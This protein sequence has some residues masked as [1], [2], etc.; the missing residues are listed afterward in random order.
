MLPHVISMHLIALQGELGIERREWI[1]EKLGEIA[2]FGP[3]SL[4]V[5]DLTDVS[6]AD[7]TLLHAL[8]QVKK[9]I[10]ALP[11]SGVYV[12]APKYIERLFQI[13]ELD[14]TF[15]LFENVLSA[16]WYGLASHITGADS[17]PNLVG[18]QT[19]DELRR[20]AEIETA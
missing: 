12:V 1:E 10:D 7:T 14:R 4:T 3:N 15:P 19:G 9:H 13:T 8:I 2:L 17:R 6:F 20:A 5:L 18:W 16:R 11:G